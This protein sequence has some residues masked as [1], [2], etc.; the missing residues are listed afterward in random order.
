MLT[1]SMLFAVNGP[2][3]NLN[4]G[5]GLRKSPYGK[6]WPPAELVPLSLWG[7]GGLLWWEI[8]TAV[9][10]NPGPTEEFSFGHSFPGLNALMAWYEARG[11]NDHTCT[12]KRLNICIYFCS[13]E[14]FE[15][16]SKVL[17]N[18][19]KVKG[20]CRNLT[21]WY[22]ARSWLIRTTHTYTGQP[23]RCHIS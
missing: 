10:L 15:R 7:N 22:P 11:E 2:S 8:F 3:W 1:C 13:I 20:R 18:G 17:W 19:V 14:L 16:W 21:E 5:G 12:L 9:A 23:Y 4:R 6:V